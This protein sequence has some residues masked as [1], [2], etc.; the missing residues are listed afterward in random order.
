MWKSKQVE[1]T[2]DKLAKDP[3]LQIHPHV[4]RVLNVEARSSGYNTH[5]IEGDSHPNFEIS[6]HA[7]EEDVGEQRDSGVIPSVDCKISEID[8]AFQ[9]SRI[10]RVNASLRNKKYFA[11]GDLYIRLE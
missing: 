10:N 3:D 1:V 8:V 9:L 7:S 4:P 5:D 11:N 6:D 2:L